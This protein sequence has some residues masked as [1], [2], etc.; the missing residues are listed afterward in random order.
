[1][2]SETVTEKTPAFRNITFSNITATVEKGKRAGLIWGLPESP[3]D[4]ILLQN[5]NITAENDFGIYFA[6]NVRLENCKIRTKYGLNKLSVTNAE[7]TLDGKP[8]K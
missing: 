4:N 1:Y 7:V 2:P 6:K 8:V 5:V 3:A